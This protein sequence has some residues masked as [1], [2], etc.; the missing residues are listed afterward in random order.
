MPNLSPAEMLA[1]QTILK[2]SFNHIGPSLSMPILATW[3]CLIGLGLLTRVAMR[4]TLFLLFVQM[5]GT[6]LPLFFF[7]DQT[8]TSVP[9][10]P[11]L[12]GQY[13]IKNLVLIS[14]GIVIGATVRGGPVQPE[15]GT[16]TPGRKN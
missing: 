6:L 4:L 15:S 1:S 12:E 13:I 9:F 16:K 5:A 3:E 11:T 8:F 10:V 7:P 14:A 2:L